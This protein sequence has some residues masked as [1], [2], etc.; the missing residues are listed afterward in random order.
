MPA[1]FTYNPT[2]EKVLIFG[3]RGFMAS[4]LKTLYPDAMLSQ[5]DICDSLA[6]GDELD[7]QKPTVVINAAGKTGRPNIDWCEDHKLETV[8]S[9]VEGPLVLLKACA[10]RNMY[11]VHVGSGCTY[12]GE[13]KD[14]RGFTEDE[15]PNFTG[16][17]YARTKAQIDQILKDFPV[18]QLR[19]RMPFDG[20]SHPRSLINKLRKYAKILDAENSLTYI[21]DFLN[22]TKWLIAKRETGIFNVVN[23][24][25]VSPYHMMLRYQAV[26][27]PKHV[28]E[29]LTLGN[30]GSVT[31][32][33]RSNCVLSNE[34]LKK[35]GVQ[36]KS[37]AEAL[38]EA[39][40]MMKA[41]L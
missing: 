7:E 2:M 18:L 11:W 1:D 31:K 6:V 37:V 35:A 24:G 38:E 23:S 29:R 22:A 9:N 40:L 27:D 19:V 20:S 32:A 12:E 41:S 16:S 30:L 3:G 33:G 21:P 8:M 15:T 5:V 10:D 13:G 17:F 14:G 4:H 39:L 36:L 25:T 26:V 34:K 28:F